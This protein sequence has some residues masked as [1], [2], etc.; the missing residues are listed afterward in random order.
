MQSRLTP[1]MQQEIWSNLQD[2]AREAKQLK[3]RKKPRAPKVEAWS[4]L[5]KEGKAQEIKNRLEAGATVEL[6]HLREA[7]HALVAGTGGA[8]DVFEILLEHWHPEKEQGKK[9][10]QV[11]QVYRWLGLLSDYACDHIE[12]ETAIV[13]VG[14]MLKKG[15]EPSSQLWGKILFDEDPYDEN[16]LGTWFL[17]YGWRENLEHCQGF[18]TPINLYK[19]LLYA[20]SNQNE[21]MNALDFIEQVAEQAKGQRYNFNQKQQREIIDSMWAVAPN[22]PA[23]VR[24]LTVGLE[25]LGIATPLVDDRLSISV[26]QDDEVEVRQVGVL[27]K[28]M[29]I[30]QRVFAGL[31]QEPQ[32]EK[33]LLEDLKRYEELLPRLWIKAINMPYLL[34]AG[35]DLSLRDSEQETVLFGVMRDETI[36]ISEEFHRY[37][38]GN[39][40]EIENQ[41][42]KQQQNCFEGWDRRGLEPQVVYKGKR[43]GL[44][45]YHRLVM[46]EHL[47]AVLP[48]GKATKRPTVHL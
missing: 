15:L 14:A 34:R 8:K 17:E 9:Q 32:L 40:D 39:F 21:K 13:A 3:N 12:G 16:T 31:C 1:A 11:D 43:R 28:A 48:L 27:F 47:K 23:Q 20:F 24:R 36:R 26:D 18:L 44:G 2:M 38:V 4:A 30:N 22:S 6:S 33:M 41:R 19:S 37:L 35:V 10:R 45:E 46:S 29:L 25:K 5:I 42:N 7:A